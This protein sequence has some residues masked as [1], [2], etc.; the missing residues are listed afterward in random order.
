MVRGT[1]NGEIDSGMQSKSSRQRA[2][3]NSLEVQ[4]ERSVAK[5]EI[6]VAESNLKPGDTKF[7]DD[8]QIGITVQIQWAKE[9]WEAMATVM[10]AS[11]PKVKERMSH[12]ALSVGGAISVPGV[13]A[14]INTKTRPTL[15]FWRHRTKCEEESRWTPSASSLAANSRT[16]PRP[17][18][19]RCSR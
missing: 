9:S 7:H 19:S 14:T 16:A 2:K 5:L 13:A 8:I 1:G 17:A 3:R 6:N 11:M 15:T 10:N 4:H 18:T 12:P